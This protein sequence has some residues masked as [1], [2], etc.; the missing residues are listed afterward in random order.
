VPHSKD[1]VEDKVHF[2]LR[3]GVLS[4]IDVTPV[5]GVDVVPGVP[6]VI[7]LLCTEIYSNISRSKN[8][9]FRAQIWCSKNCGSN[10]NKI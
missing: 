2:G 5:V 9:N 8:N 1:V 7:Y 10:K 4:G 3:A 6:R